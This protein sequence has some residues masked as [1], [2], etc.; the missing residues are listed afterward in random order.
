MNATL[1]DS[2]RNYLLSSV[3]LREKVA[4]R[5]TESIILAIDIMEKSLQQGHKI[6]L[7]GNGGSA[8][9]CQ[10]IAAELV[11]S[12]RNRDRKALAAIA[13][14]TD[15]SILTAYS[16]DYNF[17]GVFD[18][19]I[20]A[21]G[22]AGDVLWVIS[23]SGRSENVLLAVRAAHSKRI[24]TLGLTQLGGALA[25]IV[26][27]AIEIPSCDTQMLQEIFLSIEHFICLELERRLCK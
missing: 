10:H 20:E 13:L 16:N 3:T 19:Q 17:D 15:T 27:I 7:C 9:D 11:C 14:T 4:E 21:L 5:C 1:E 24:R 12:I 6:L 26:D 25:K 23:A 22:I 8:A 18:R 2:V